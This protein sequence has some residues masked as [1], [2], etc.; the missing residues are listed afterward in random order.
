MSIRWFFAG[1]LICGC[2][3]SSV[4]ADEP[5]EVRQ[6]VT[7]RFQPGRTADALEL[8]A[9]VLRPIYRSTAALLRFRGYRE[10]ESP[11]PLDLIVVS[12]FAGMAGMD[13]ANA[14]QRAAA[15]AA[16]TSMGALYGRL[17]SFAQFHHDQFV[18]MMPGLVRPGSA[19]SSAPLLMLESVGRAVSAAG[20]G[21]GD[22]LVSPGPD[23][24]RSRHG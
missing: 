24:I 5:V 3:V 20:P 16:G 12:T 17:G 18:E 6:L 14:Q 10:A 9:E 4:R 23:G 7:F 22:R 15:E 11:E 21:P 19:S 8:F 2:L 1:A 13:A